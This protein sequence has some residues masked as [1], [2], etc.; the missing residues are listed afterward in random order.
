[1]V[2]IESVLVTQTFS[3]NFGVMVDSCYYPNLVSYNATT[4]NAPQRVSR[5]AIRHAQPE[6]AHTVAEV[7]TSSFHA[8]EGLWCWTYPLF[9]L[10]IYEDLRSRLNSSVPYS[11]CLVASTHLQHERGYSEQ[12]IGTVDITVRS[13]Y[14]WSNFGQQYPYISNLAV[15]KSYRRQGVAGKLLSRCEQIALEWGFREISLHVLDDNHQAKNLYLRNGFQVEKTE[16]HF[17]SWLW[18][19]PKRLFLQKEIQ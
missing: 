5:I 9:K 2:K 8:N 19:S 18:H 3:H 1:M 15:S 16:G 10:G 12:V 17:H 13:H 14:C 6:D 4:T 7:L 11:S